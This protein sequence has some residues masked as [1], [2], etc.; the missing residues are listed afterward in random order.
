MAGQGSRTFQIRIRL[1]SP[2]SFARRT[3]CRYFR[4]PPRFL[5]HHDLAIYDSIGGLLVQARKLESFV[6]TEIYSSFSTLYPTIYKSV[7]TL[8]RSCLSGTHTAQYITME[9]QAQSGGAGGR[10]C[11]NCESRS[12]FVANRFHMPTM[13]FMCGRHGQMY[14]S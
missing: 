1:E 4:A 6:T 2:T 12:R 14:H 3:C 8:P 9:Y 5:H 11:Y 10:G 13:K 7:C